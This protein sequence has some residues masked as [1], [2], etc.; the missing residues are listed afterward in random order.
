[1]LALPLFYAFVRRAS[2]SYLVCTCCIYFITVCWFSVE[3]FS[4]FEAESV[5]FSISNNVI[6]QDSDTYLDG[7]VSLWHCT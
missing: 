7:S 3:A 1:M 6:G 4:S 5:L 2:K